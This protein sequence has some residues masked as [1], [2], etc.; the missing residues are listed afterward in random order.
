MRKYTTAESVE[1][2]DSQQENVIEQH[3]SKTGKTSVADL[4]DEEKEQLRSELGA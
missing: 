3:L 1:V 4:T 2:L